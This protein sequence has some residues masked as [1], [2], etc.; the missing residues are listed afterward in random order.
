MFLILL[1]LIKK[2]LNKYFAIFK[3]LLILDLHLIKI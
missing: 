3:T 2:L 1:T